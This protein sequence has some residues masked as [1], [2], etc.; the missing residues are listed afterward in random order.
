MR[1]L[2][3]DSSVIIASLLEKEPRHQEALKIWE[4]ILSG[5]SIAIM[6]H[7]VLVEVVAAIRRRTGSKDLACEVRK[8]ILE[9]ENLSFVVL[10]QKAALEASDLA[11][12]TGVRGMDAL[13]IQVVREFETELITF[14]EEMIQKAG[15]VDRAE[16]DR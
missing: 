16:N 7:S 3:I 6:P 5:E 14:D 13:V 8:E 9:I 11:I 12:R 10:D 15:K 2:T 4:S 1:K